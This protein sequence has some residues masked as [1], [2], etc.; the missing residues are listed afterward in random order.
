[1]RRLRGITLIEMIIALVLMAIAITTFAS[2]LMPQI[3]DSALPSYQTRAASLAQGFLS[4]IMA[5]SFD[6]NSDRDGGGIRCNE[7]VVLCT[8]AKALGSDSG[9][10]NS[11]Q[12][13]DVDDYIGCWGTPET[14]SQCQGDTRGHI[15]NVLGESSADKYRNF[16]VEVSVVYDNLNSPIPALE[17]TDYKKITVSIFA[18]YTQPL[19]LVAIRGNY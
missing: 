19:T 11:S 12:F 5:R 10:S 17:A 3:R 9:E 7:G 15:T 1:M 18:S 14:L 6:H 4:Q 16:R 2:F 8:P 13:N